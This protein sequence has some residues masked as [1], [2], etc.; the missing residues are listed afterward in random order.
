[1]VNVPQKKDPFGIVLKPIFPRSTL[2]WTAAATPE[3][4]FT[5]P[6]ERWQPFP[7]KRRRPQCTVKNA[8]KHEKNLA[9]VAH[10]PN[11]GKLGKNM[12]KLAILANGKIG[13]NLRQ[14]S[15]RQEVTEFPLQKTVLF[16]GKYKDSRC[17]SQLRAQHRLI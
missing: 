10:Q 17:S 11:V 16:P 13:K 14:I 5:N 1:M 3:R 15:W 8:R 2:H 9:Q 6:K 4:W 7:A 12:H